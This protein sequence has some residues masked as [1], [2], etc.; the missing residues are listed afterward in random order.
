MEAP[1][2]L[3]EGLPEGSCAFEQE[4]DA[5]EGKVGGEIDEADEGALYAEAVDG[6][7]EGDVARCVVFD[8]LARK[9]GAF[10]VVGCGLGG[11]LSEEDVEDHDPAET[12]LE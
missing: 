1:E 12:G 10:L 9:V 3:G 2:E 6:F 8:H 7:G 4:F 11:F 5:L